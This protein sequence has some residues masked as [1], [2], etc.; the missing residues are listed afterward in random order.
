[1]NSYEKWIEEEIKW[2]GIY[3][4]KMRRQALCV[5][6]PSILGG[7]ALLLGV[8]QL[9]GSENVEDFVNGVLGGFMIGALICG[10]Y[11]LVLLPGLNPRRYGKKIDRSVRDLSLNEM[12]KEQ[13]AQEMLAADEEHRISY[14]LQGPGSK[15]TPG[16]FVLT[17]HYALL[18]GSSPY[19][20]LIRLSDIAEIRRG[21]EKKMAEERR[22]KS[23]TVYW[24]TLY[25]IGFYRKDR[26]QRNLTQ[27]DLPDEAFG[28]F[29]QDIRDQVMNL[30]A[31]SGIWIE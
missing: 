20:I 2:I 9:I 31:E 14:V 13:L 8:L 18:E 27:K 23:K 5:V 30:L 16:R 29:R 1:M 22:A 12:E 7:T 19:A 21:E 11:L 10:I 17:E 26:F 25:T 4:S 15:G 3:C 28:F 6:A 24:F